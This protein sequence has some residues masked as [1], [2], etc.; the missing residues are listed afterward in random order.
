[1]TSHKSRIKAANA[2]TATDFIDQHLRPSAA[3]VDIAHDLCISFATAATISDS[4]FDGCFDLVRSTSAAAYTASSR[5]WSSEEK[6]TEM[7]EADMKYLMIRAVA[8]NAEASIPAGHTL[9]FGD[10]GLDLGNGEQS[11]VVGFLS[12]MLTREDRRDV[13]YCYEVH[14]KEDYQGR[15]LGAQ[16]MLL[17]ERIGESVGVKKGMLT[18]FTSNDAAMRLYKRIGY[19]WYDEEAVPE[20]KSLRS[21]V[22]DP[23]KPSYVILAKNLRKVK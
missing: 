6:R 16:L 13:I 5:G 4:D 3:S 7:R 8:R 23:P 1:M 18:V 21:G 11:S 10:Q 14:L 19:E 22:T 15:G 9:N 20:G 2:L 17:M 12:F